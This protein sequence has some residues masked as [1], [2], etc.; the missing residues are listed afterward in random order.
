MHG[1]LQRVRKQLAEVTTRGKLPPAAVTEQAREVLS[2]VN[3]PACTPEKV[4]QVGNFVEK[5]Y[6]KSSPADAVA[7]M[8]RLATA[9]PELGDNWQQTEV[10]L[11][12]QS[13]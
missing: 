12:L 2:A 10:L 4:V 11:L 3:R 1:R 7:T 13:R 5:A 8:V 9:V 6:I